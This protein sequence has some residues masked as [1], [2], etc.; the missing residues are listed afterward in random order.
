LL[1]WNGKSEVQTWLA[2]LF[3]VDSISEHDVLGSLGRDGWAGVVR[4]LMVDFAQD[5][6]IHHSA[7]KR[8]RLIE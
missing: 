8:Q 3:A 7:W 2:N 4:H 5:A 1:A 6:A